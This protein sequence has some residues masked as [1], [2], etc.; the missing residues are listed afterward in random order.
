VEEELEADDE[1]RGDDEDEEGAEDL[2]DG[3]EPDDDL[4]T[5]AASLLQVLCH[6][7]MQL[8]S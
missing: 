5:D 4:G 6:T 1:L 3:G 8:S 2:L 7:C